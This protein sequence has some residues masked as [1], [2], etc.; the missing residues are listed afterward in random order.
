MKNH[1]HKLI[2]NRL[3]VFLF[4]CIATVSTNAQHL[5]FDLGNANVEMGLNF[6]PTFF[7]GDL[8]GKVGKGT[9]FIKDLNYEFTKLMKG[10]FVTV[11][12][13]DYLGLR[14]A[15]QLTYVEG[16]D[17]IINTHGVDELW[18]K[19]RNLDFKSNIWEVYGAVEFFPLQYLYRNDY[20]YDPRLKP[21]FFGGVGLFHFNPKG[22]LTDQAG[23]V[24]WHELQPLHTEGQGFPEYPNSK[25]YKLTQMNIPF[26]GGFKYL[27]SDKVNLDLELLYRKTFTDYI[28]D[29]STTYID[30][31]YFDKYLNASDAVIARAISDKTIGIVTPGVGRYAPGVQRGT[32]V[33][34]DAYFSFLL[35]LGIRFGDGNGNGGGG[36]GGGSGSYGR[37]ARNSTRCPVRF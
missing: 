25:E 10:A 14:L 3:F 33:N 11:Y 7:L 28:D 20:D 21:Y 27:V 32:P 19:Q 5:L 22:S 24:T 37:G 29:V 15:G 30:P 8:G 35:K 26:G 31:I 13:N 12:P 17:A 1:L 34:K 6:G 23:N 4:C 16:V 2:R 9:T 36:Y 18:R